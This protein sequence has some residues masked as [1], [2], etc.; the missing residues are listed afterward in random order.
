MADYFPRPLPKA[1]VSIPEVGNLL[2]EFDGFD[3]DPNFPFPRHS[4][5]PERWPI[6]LP[7]CGPP[8]TPIPLLILRMI[9]STWEYT[10]PAWDNVK[11]SQAGHVAH[12]IT[13][14]KREHRYGIGSH[15]DATT[16]PK[17][18]GLGLFTAPVR[19]TV[20]VNAQGVQH[21]YVST[22]P[23]DSA[24]ATDWNLHETIPRT[25]AVTFRGDS[26]SPKDVIS[27]AGGFYPPV[28]RKDR[29]YLE[30]NL[31]Q[32]FADYMMRRYG[33]TIELERFLEAHDKTAVKRE[34]KHLFADF[35][36]WKKIT[37]SEAGH[38]GRMVETELLKGYIS[39]AR[40]ID[41]SLG[42][43]TYGGV[44]DGW[45]YLVVVHS[46]FIVPND[47]EYWG[48]EESEIAQWGRI[49]AERIVGFVKVPKNQVPSGPIYIRR[50]FRFN[51]V[52]AFRHM[53]KVMSGMVP[54]QAG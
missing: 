7:R 26:R 45:L 28:T 41:T 34:D 18:E 19:P 46:G 43:A 11:G 52:E 44:Q 16:G 48:T 8:L 4:P 35:M 17:I 53:F 6:V 22:Q 14:G 47:G 51:E 12:G 54:G 24:I 38:L 32:G 5:P 37:E 27:V 21:G 31:F 42:F 3:P 1:S 9:R 39:T 33:R 2:T 50:S 15:R 25:N 23:N 36:T 30:K 29:P 40:R 10:S 20:P 13:I 49:P